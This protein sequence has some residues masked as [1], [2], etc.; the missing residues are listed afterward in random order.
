MMERHGN[1][2]FADAEL[3]DPALCH[4][5]GVSLAAWFERGPGPS[6]MRAPFELHLRRL[7]DGVFV[8]SGATPNPQPEERERFVV[9][10]KRAV[11]AWPGLTSPEAP[12]LAGALGLGLVAVCWGALKSSQQRLALQVG[13]ASLL[14]VVLIWVWAALQALPLSLG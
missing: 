2:G 10:V 3:Y 4:S 8:V 7:P 1:L 6:Y 14:G 13:L 9:A 11:G 5:A 12:W